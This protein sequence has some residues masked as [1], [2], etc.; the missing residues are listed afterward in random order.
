MMIAEHKRTLKSPRIGWLSALRI[1][2][3]RRAFR[4]IGQPAGER[5]ASDLLGLPILE[6]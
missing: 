4:R 6:V 3:L 5:A 2:K 1:A